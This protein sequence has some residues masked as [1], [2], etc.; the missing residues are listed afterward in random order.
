[1][2]EYVVNSGDVA[3]HNVQ[4]QPSVVTWVSFIDDVPE[5]EILSNGAAPIFYTRDGS[6]PTINGS[7]TRL[8]PAM[9]AGVLI[10]QI[11]MSHHHDVL[12]FISAGSPTI[13]VQVSRFER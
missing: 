8:I 12:K 6:E 4:L 7:N 5:V 3:V 1:M 9:A 2:A 13:S 10:D 11:L